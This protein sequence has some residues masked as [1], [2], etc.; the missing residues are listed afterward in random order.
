MLGRLIGYILFAV[1]AWFI[2]QYVAALSGQS[3]LFLGLVY[4][5]LAFLL[6]RY[7]M[8][9]PTSRCAGESFPARANFPALMGL[10]TGLNLCPPFLLAF[11][12]ATENPTLEHSLT[13]FL[14]FFIGTSLYLLPLPFLGAFKGYPHLKMI[15]KISAT[16]MS[17][18][19]AYT[20]ILMVLGGVVKS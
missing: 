4:V 20:G 10:L 2:A 18:Y 17:V 3:G 16:L 5:L 11:A 9:A 7:G 6:F 15:G 1:S 12:A 14:A 19:Y 13:F 8:H